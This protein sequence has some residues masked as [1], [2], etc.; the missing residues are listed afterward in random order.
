MDVKLRE[1][2]PFSVAGLQ[3]RTLNAA[4]Q[5]AD[6]ARIGPMWQR[7]YVEGLFDKI[8]PRQADSFVYGVY[9]NYESDAS[10]H[11]DVTAGVALEGACADYPSV[12]VQ[13]GDYLVFS[14]KGAMPDCVIQTWG[15]IWAYFQD[16]PQVRRAF[17]TDFEVYTSADS[18][19][20]YIG[21]EASQAASR[22][23]N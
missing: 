13:G 11:F 17:A 22:S 6:S 20:I 5:Q 14:A 16:N 15:L 19:A 18:V 10:G 3:V 7:F 9:S 2:L 8:S 4:E 1:V 12:A 23:S 21:I